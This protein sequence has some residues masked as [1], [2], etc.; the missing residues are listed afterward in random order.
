MTLVDLVD[1]IFAVL[2]VTGIFYILAHLFI[3]AIR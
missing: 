3:W 2:I 1:D